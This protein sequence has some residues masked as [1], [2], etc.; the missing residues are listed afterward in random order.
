MLV[1]ASLA[2]QKKTPQVCLLP[3]FYLPDSANQIEADTETDNG[4]SRTSSM[5][6]NRS[7]L[8]KRAKPGKQRR[9]SDSFDTR[10]QYTPYWG[11]QQQ[12]WVPQPQMQ[13]MP[14]PGAPYG[15]PGQASYPT[16]VAP[17]YGQQAPY[18]AIPNMVPASPYAQYPPSQVWIGKEP[19][20]CFL[21]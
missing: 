12:T 18:P 17:A 19:L 11:P 13:Y 16:P 10:H 8:G 20:R 4:M 15:S 14:P 5:S 2:V 6:A 21:Y 9:D 7:N 1:S 3:E